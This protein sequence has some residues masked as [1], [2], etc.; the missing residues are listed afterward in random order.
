MGELADDHFVELFWTEGTGIGGDVYSGPPADHPAYGGMDAY[1]QRHA[2][3]PWS[4]LAQP[5]ADKTTVHQAPPRRP[6]MSVYDL[7]AREPEL[8][9]CPCCGVAA[10]VIEYPLGVSCS[11]GSC[12]PGKLPVYL[13]ERDAVDAGFESVVERWNTAKLNAERDALV[14]HKLAEQGGE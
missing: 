14:W 8:H 9:P 1:I 12:V 3:M 2:S 13:S 5:K 4:A 7:L 10:R 11:R 6:L